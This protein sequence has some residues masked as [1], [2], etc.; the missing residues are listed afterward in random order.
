MDGKRPLPSAPRQNRHGRLIVSLRL[1]STLLSGLRQ[2]WFR[3]FYPLATL[4]PSP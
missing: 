3:V 1:L 2:D 4:S